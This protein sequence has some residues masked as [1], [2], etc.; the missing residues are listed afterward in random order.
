MK[1]LLLILALA[2]AMPLA[3]T[4]CS[5]PTTRNTAVATLKAVGHT[6]EAA[7]SLSAQLYADGKIT[8]AQAYAVFDAYNTRY[9]P[10]FRVARTAAR[11][12]G[13]AVAPLELINI[14]NDLAALVASYR[15]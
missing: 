12:D 3:H 10:A 1:N 8:E 4:G 2:T 11:F 7:V 13:N 15:K 9:L 14:A 5:T 6:A